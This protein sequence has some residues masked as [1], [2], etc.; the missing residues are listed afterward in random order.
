MEI[1]GSNTPPPYPVTYPA[2]GN[3]T[4]K[5]DKPARYTA[6][7]G[8]APVKEMILPDDTPPPLTVAYPV[9]TENTSEKPDKP[10]GYTAAGTPA[11]IEMIVPDDTPPPL[12]NVAYSAA[13]GNTTGKPDKPAGYTRAGTSVMKMIVPDADVVAEMTAAAE[14]FV[15]TGPEVTSIPPFPPFSLLPKKGY[16]SMETKK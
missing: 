1:S 3:R 4:G 2:K 15:Q 6:A 5:P 16:L 8:A 14:I 9:M 7:K 12:L 13:V 11:A 10:A